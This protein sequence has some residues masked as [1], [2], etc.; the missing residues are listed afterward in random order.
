[1]AEFIQSIPVW[2]VTLTLGAFALG[3]WLNK[4]TGMAIF[5][6]LLLGSI[7]VIVFLSLARIPLEDYQERVSF[8]NY[9]LLPATVS[10]A[11][12]LYE[13]WQILRKNAVAVLCGIAAGSVTSMVSIIAVGWLLR[14]DPVISAS[15]MTKSVTTAIGVEVA[16][17]LGGIGSLAGSVIVLT[18]IVGNLSAAALCR[19]CR[20]RD[21]V[22]RGVAIGTGSHAV[23][24]AKALQMGPVEGAVSSVSIAVAGVL[25]AVICPLLA[26]FLP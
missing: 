20:L 17:E 19:I 18:G 15:M 8:L 25:T 12:P 9:L 21:P 1:M 11:V 6:P 7:F 13:Q 22:A 26:N 14:I 23:G 2:G 24:T 16:Q 4:K 10:L 5:N 3:T